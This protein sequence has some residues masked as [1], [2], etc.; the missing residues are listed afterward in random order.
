VRWFRKRPPKDRGQ[1]QAVL[2]RAIGATDAG[3][4]APWVMPAIS[5]HDGKRA[6]SGRDRYDPLRGPPGPPRLLDR[7]QPDVPV[8]RDASLRVWWAP[9]LGLVWL[10][11]TLVAHGVVRRKRRSHG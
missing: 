8:E 2:L 11:G 5:F 7:L 4:V 10:V 9:L 1:L 6:A 3:R